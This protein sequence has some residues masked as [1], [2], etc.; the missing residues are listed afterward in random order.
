MLFRYPEQLLEFGALAI[1][2]SLPDPNTGPYLLSQY[3]AYPSCPAVK[4]IF[5]GGRPL[6]L[7]RLNRN[8]FCALLFPDVPIKE[9]YNMMHCT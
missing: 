6:G 9:K 3:I 4:D 5:V 7:T 8:A 1:N 2:R